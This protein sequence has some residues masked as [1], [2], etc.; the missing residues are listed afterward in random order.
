MCLIAYSPDGPGDYDMSLLKNAMD[1]NSDGYGIM[2]PTSRGRLKTIRSMGLWDTFER[3]MLNV[4]AR[5]PV[6][7]HFRYGTHGAID[8]SMCHPFQISQNVAMMH[9]GVLHHFE[10]DKLLS[11]TAELC[12]DILRPML[13]YAPDILGTSAFERALEIIIGDGNKL[14]F[15]DGGGDA[16]IINERDGTWQGGIWYSNTYSL[17][18]L[19]AVPKILPAYAMDDWEPPV[20][21]L[22]PADST[23]EPADY[24]YDS[25]WEAVHLMSEK[26]IYELVYDDPEGACEYIVNTR[27]DYLR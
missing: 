24:D 3:D 11:D 1:H 23:W 14:L 20:A 21:K 25:K 19:R 6:A 16:T 7:V 4:P 13:E 22:K 9:N 8:E 17:T 26:E 18:P 10:G 5:A 15:M 12:R 2:Y 27:K